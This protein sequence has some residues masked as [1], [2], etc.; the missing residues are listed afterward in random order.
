[1]TGRIRD[2]LSGRTQQKYRGLMLIFFVGGMF[3]VLAAQ[4]IDSNIREGMARKMG[5]KPEYKK[6]A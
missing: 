4:A 6:V 1:M 5:P 3:A 2:V